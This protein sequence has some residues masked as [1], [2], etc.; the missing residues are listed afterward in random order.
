MEEETLFE[1][2]Y[3]HYR[4]Q[5]TG[6]DSKPTEINKSSHTRC[7]TVSLAHFHIESRYKVWKSLP[8]HA[9][10]NKELL[11][12]VHIQYTRS[13][14]F[15]SVAGQIHHSWLGFDFKPKYTV[16]LLDI[17]EKATSYLIFTTKIKTKMFLVK[18]IRDYNCLNCYLNNNN[19]NKSDYIHYTHTP[20]HR[21]YKPK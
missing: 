14:L 3:S 16:L 21:H 8:C 2:Q 4:K 5:K 20:I 11:M 18:I 12:T 19:N 15:S 17:Q 7:V 10:L 9:F 6:T 1:M 13:V